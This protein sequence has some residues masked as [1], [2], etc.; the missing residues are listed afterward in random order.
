MNCYGYF[1][2]NFFE[3]LK[4][5]LYIEENWV[6][7]LDRKCSHLVVLYCVD[8]YGVVVIWFIHVIFVLKGMNYYGIF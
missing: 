1:L 5:M 4:N 7:I 8:Q 2:L 6:N 3:I